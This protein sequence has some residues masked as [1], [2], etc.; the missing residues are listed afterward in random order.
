LLD[1]ADEAFATNPHQP[2]AQLARERGWP[3]LDWRDGNP[4]T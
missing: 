3:I 1:F 2:L 4:A